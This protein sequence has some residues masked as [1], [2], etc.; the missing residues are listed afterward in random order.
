[1]ADVLI[2]YLGNTVVV[3]ATALLLVCLLQL[4][5]KGASFFSKKYPG[6]LFIL[7]IR[8]EKY[9][10]TV[11]IFLQRTALGLLLLIFLATMTITGLFFVSKKYTDSTKHWSA[12]QSIA[13][14]AKA[15]SP[16]SPE[17]EVACLQAGGIWAQISFDPKKYCNL[18]TT[19]AGAIC[20]D[21]S[22]CEGT[23]V[24]EHS[25]GDTFG[26]CSERRW[27]NCVNQIVNG[28]SQGLL[29]AD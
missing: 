1:M 26:K 18:P 29:C 12:E 8:V 14:D 4:I 27:V 19:D 2:P 10:P 15:D 9:Y 24:G 22:Q 11:N 3:L 23:C 28:K 25:S 16:D 6:K 7:N 20:T 13:R 21:R 5:V 17:T